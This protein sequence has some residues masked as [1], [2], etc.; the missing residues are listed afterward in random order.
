[1]G[2]DLNVCAP[3]AAAVSAVGACTQNSVS[4]STASS[5]C[6]PALSSSGA[7]APS[8][9]WANAGEVERLH[10]RACKLV[11]V[12]VFALG[13]YGAFE[14]GKAKVAARATHSLST[15]ALATGASIHKCL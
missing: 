1:M 7:C 14:E 9:E 6:S 8:A 15:L 10:R 3:N 11:A 13:I 12:S 2:F 4:A 5:N